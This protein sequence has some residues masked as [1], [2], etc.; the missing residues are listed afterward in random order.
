M[1]RE[2]KE[3]IKR[4]TEEIKVVNE[5]HGRDIEQIDKLEKEKEAGFV[6]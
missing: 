5:Q 6:V 1:K 4:L 3:E 2:Y